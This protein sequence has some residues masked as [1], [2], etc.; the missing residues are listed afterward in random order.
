MA[1][2]LEV[3]PRGVAFVLVEL[4]VALGVMSLELVLVLAVLLV[5]VAVLRVES[6]E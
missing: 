6:L 1:V 3:L 4:E 5:S 2:I